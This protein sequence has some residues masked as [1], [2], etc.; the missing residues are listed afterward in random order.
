MCCTWKHGHQGH[1]F[2][3]ETYP[4]DASRYCRCLGLNQGLTDDPANHGKCCGAASSDDGLC[5]RCRNTCQQKDA[6]HTHETAKYANEAAG[7]V[8]TGV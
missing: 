5:D 8:L 2:S 7:V 1:A 6:G 4:H 3:A